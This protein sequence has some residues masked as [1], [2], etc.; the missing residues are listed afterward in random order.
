VVVGRVKVR[1]RVREC[2]CYGGGGV[3]RGWSGGG[4]GGCRRLGMLVRLEVKGD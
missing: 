4:R 2:W 1:D 3:R